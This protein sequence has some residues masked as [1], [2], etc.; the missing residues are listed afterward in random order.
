MDSNKTKQDYLLFAC[1]LLATI[2]SFYGTYAFHLAGAVKA[3]VWLGWLVSVLAL[4]YFTTKGQEVFAFANDA[5]IELQKVV[6]PTRQETI[7][8]TSIVM[9]MVVVAGFL[10]WGVDVGMMWII[11]K[12]TQLG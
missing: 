3:L 2:A 1:I 7:Q 6:W 9:L 12:I 8:T 10:L 5:K 4:G 11:G